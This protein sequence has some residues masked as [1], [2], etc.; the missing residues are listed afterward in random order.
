MTETASREGE[1]PIASPSSCLLHLPFKQNLFGTVLRQLG[2][3][4]FCIFF[5][6]SFADHGFF[7]SSGHHHHGKLAPRLLLIL[8]S[9]SLMA[10]ILQGFSFI[11]PPPGHESTGAL[12][13]MPLPP[14]RD[15]SAAI[16]KAGGEMKAPAS[17]QTPL[18]F[19]N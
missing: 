4:H 1:T 6:L 10:P 13:T 16:L 14:S 11:Q 12:P 5:S 9:Q 8:C 19:H 17:D 2:S 3:L 7:S 15:K 18:P